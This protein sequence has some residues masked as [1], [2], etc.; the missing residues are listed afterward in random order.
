MAIAITQCSEKLA[1]LI[2]QLAKNFTVYM[3]MVI[4][5]NGLHFL[6]KPY[7]QPR[8]TSDI[9]VSFPL[10]MNPMQEHAEK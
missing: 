6:L 2:L 9:A 1:Y 7:S 4:A 10:V 8:I 5:C 3:V